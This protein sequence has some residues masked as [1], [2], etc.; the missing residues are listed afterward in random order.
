MQSKA[1]I[2]TLVVPEAIAPLLRR[3]RVQL[4]L[5]LL[6][7]GRKRK[8]PLAYFD[9]LHGLV[10]KPSAVVNYTS[11]L[12]T[13]GTAEIWQGAEVHLHMF[14]SMVR[15]RLDA[16]GGQELRHLLR[17]HLESGVRYHGAC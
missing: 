17:L 14:S 15:S 12:A 5:A 16:V 11:T 7:P 13:S 6:W 9:A 3:R 8:H 1:G 10:Y 4:H 2:A